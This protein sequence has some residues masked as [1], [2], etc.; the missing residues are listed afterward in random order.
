MSG[1]KIGVG[2]NHPLVLEGRMIKT[3]ADYEAALARAEELMDAEEGTREADELDVLATLIEA[4]E[5]KHWRL[6]RKA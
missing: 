3:E 5:D 1:R 4:Y 6:V 2:F